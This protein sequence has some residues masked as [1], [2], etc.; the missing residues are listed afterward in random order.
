MEPKVGLIAIRNMCGIKMKLRI[1]EV[2]ESKFFCGG[3][4]FDR[5]TG[6]EIDEELGWGPYP[7]MTGSYIEGFE[8]EKV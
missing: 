4:V 3:W 5:K 1:T 7:Q 8:E 6:A 2:T